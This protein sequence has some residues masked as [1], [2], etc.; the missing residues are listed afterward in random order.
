MPSEARGLQPRPQPSGRQ[1]HFAR[2]KVSG[3][4]A[5]RGL[6]HVTAQ[7]L[8]AS[9]TPHEWIGPRVYLLGIK[10]GRVLSTQKEATWYRASF[11]RASCCLS[12]LPQ[13]EAL[14]PNLPWPVFCTGHL[15]GNREGQ[16]KISLVLLVSI[17]SILYFIYQVSRRR[18]LSRLRRRLS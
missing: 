9:P 8:Q 2:N 17:N 16:P 4:T 15:F 14:A 13:V 5:C 12:P 6:H 18:G 7:S 1:E 10:G 3:Q 11:G